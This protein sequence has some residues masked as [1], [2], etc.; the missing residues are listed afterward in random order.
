[1]FEFAKSALAHLGIDVRRVSSAT[2]FAKRLNLVLEHIGSDC[3]LDV[4]A[5]RGQFALDLRRN[6]FEG[7][8]ISF[9]PLT[10]A[11]QMLEKAA[12]SDPDWIV[13]P[14]AVVGEDCGETMINI[15]ENSVSSSVMGMTKAHTGA[16]AAS[17]Y[18][19]S[20]CV[21]KTTIDSVVDVY[22]IDATST[23]IKVDTQGYEWQVL[24]GASEFLQQ[25]PGLLLESSLIELYEGQR[26][27]LEIVGR[28][29]SLG[30]QVW[31]VDRGFFDPRNGRTLQCDLVFVRE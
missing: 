4:G 2:R 8:I 21:E 17:Q 19:G 15:S 16:H 7:K 1:M 14:R 5:N 9:E 29:K 6:G 18:I 30:F 25:C 10:D 13:H 11:H 27:W 28:M 31:S 3:V 22:K 26:L 12:K 20:E 24:D 23:F